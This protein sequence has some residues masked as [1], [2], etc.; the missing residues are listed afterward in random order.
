[1]SWKGS[2]RR[3][4]GKS[5]IIVQ[6]FWSILYQKDSQEDLKGMCCFTLLMLP[7]LQ[8]RLLSLLSPTL[9]CPHLSGDLSFYNIC[10]H[11]IQLQFAYV[12]CTGFN[13]YIPRLSFEDISI[14][15]ECSSIYVH[16]DVVLIT[17]LKHFC[18]FDQLTQEWPAKQ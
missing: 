7:C 18:A 3:I 14:G 5:E 17:Q 8:L 16:D 1:M 11:F 4:F 12:S 13:K 9:T 15:Q 6:E 2:K 10:H